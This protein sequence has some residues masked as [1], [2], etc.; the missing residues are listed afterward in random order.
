MVFT[1]NNPSAI[2]SRY[3]IV[4]CRISAQSAYFLADRIGGRLRF[5]AFGRYRRGGTIGG[6]STV[7]EVV[8]RFLTIR[9]LPNH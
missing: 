1:L 7:F 6:G 3:P 9:D 5:E 8:G 2:C 4:I